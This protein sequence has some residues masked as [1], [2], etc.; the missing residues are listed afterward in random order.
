MLTKRYTMR[1]IHLIVTKNYSEIVNK[2]PAVQL[3]MNICSLPKY[4]ALEHTYASVFPVL[5]KR[6]V[7]TFW[8]TP[9]HL[10]NVVLNQVKTSSTDVKSGE[11]RGF[12]SQWKFYVTIS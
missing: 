7:N 4:S 8:Y 6:L 3:I 9:V 1:I 5:Q 11:Y 12:R 10:T 2:A